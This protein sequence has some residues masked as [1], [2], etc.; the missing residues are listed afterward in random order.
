MFVGLTSRCVTLP[1]GKSISQF[2]AQIVNL[3]LTCQKHKDSTWRTE[4]RLQG[5]YSVCVYISV[6]LFSRLLTVH[7]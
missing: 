5:G 6:E 4:A 7:I 1:E 3:R 2:S